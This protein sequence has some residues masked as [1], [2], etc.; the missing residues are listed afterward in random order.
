MKVG[1]RI[2]AVTSA[3]V[4]GT[5]AVYATFDL[6]DAAKERRERL[7]KETESLTSSLRMSFSWRR[8]SGVASNSIRSWWRLALRPSVF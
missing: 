6:R 5:L 4:A 2:T 1:T 8:A 3:L 7:E